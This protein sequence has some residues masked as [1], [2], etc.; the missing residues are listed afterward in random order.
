L[1]A[2]VV[3]RCE[4]QWWSCQAVASAPWAGELTWQFQHM[5]FALMAAA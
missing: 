5:R 1:M 3:L 2:G 4:M